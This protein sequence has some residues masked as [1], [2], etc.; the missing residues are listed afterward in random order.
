[1]NTDHSPILIRAAASDEARAILRL[2]QAAF[3]M[4]GDV[5]DPPSSVFHETVDDVRQAMHEG[6]VIVAYRDGVLLGAARV[7]PLLEQQALYC[8]RLAVDPRAQGSG[9]GSDL[10]NAVERRAADEG[11]AAVVLGV[12]VQLEGN[13]RFFAKRGYTLIGEHS[14]PGY[15]S[16]TYVRLRKDL[17]P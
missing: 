2:T 4:H 17:K 7:R 14:H 8:G 9:V 15:T 5:L 12:R 13:R 16:T 10:M 3:A 11:Y 1:M 6:T